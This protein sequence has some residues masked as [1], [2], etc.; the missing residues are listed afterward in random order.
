MKLTHMFLVNMTLENPPM[1]KTNLEQIYIEG[2]KAKS[3]T[4]ETYTSEPGTIATTLGCLGVPRRLSHKPCEVRCPLPWWVFLPL[5]CFVFI[6]MPLSLTLF[7]YHWDAMIF[8]LP[9]WSLSDPFLFPWSLHPLSQSAPSSKIWCAP[10]FGAPSPLAKA[11][12]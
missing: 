4:Q 8:P 3:T 6:L 1:G 12:H 7:L 11:S 5:A 2:L 10:S 9:T